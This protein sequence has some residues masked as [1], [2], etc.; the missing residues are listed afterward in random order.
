MITGRQ[1]DP[2]G[3]KKGER[4]G[5]RQKGTPNKVTYAAREEFMPYGKEATKKI[6]SIMRN[7]ETQDLQY[8]AACTVHDRIFGKPTQQQNLAGHNGGPI[9]FSMHDDEALNAAIERLAAMAAGK[10]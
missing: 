8:R 3:A 7:G 6:L 2:R 5:G 1:R 4:R 9:D 10:D